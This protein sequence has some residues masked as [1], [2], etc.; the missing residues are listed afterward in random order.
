MPMEC[1]AR[2]VGEAEMVRSY[3]YTMPKVIRLFWQSA[4]DLRICLRP[5]DMWLC[6]SI[7]DASGKPGIAARPVRKRLHVDGGW[8]CGQRLSTS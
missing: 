4:F 3:L 2:I 7:R 1:M 8:V 6:N 5:F